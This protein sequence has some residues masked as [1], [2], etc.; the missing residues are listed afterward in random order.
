MTES[1]IST[2]SEVRV[3]GCP[4]KRIDAAD[5]GD[6]TTLRAIHETPRGL[7]LLS[8]DAWARVNARHIE[9]HH[10][11]A[12]ARRAELDRTRSAVKHSFA[13]ARQA[14]ARVIGE[15]VSPD[16]LTTDE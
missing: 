4:L 15:Y 5:D 16:E 7:P 8:P 11:D 10:A 12:V 6:E 1:S 2:T 13:A 9:K 14:A 3:S